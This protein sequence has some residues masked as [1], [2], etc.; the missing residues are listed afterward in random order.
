[1]TAGSSVF[2]AVVPP[3]YPLPSPDRPNA[4]GPTIGNSNT[5]SFS[6]GPTLRM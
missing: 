1:M 5:K 2:P 4:H 6:V 3:T